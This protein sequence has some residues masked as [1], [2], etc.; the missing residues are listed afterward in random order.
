M[1]ISLIISPLCRMSYLDTKT[2]PPSAEVKSSVP[3][4]H[5]SVM[6]WEEVQKNVRTPGKSDVIRWREALS[7]KYRSQLGEP[8]VWDEDSAINRSE[9]LRSKDLS[10]LTLAAACVDLFG[11]HEAGR[12]LA[13]RT[14]VPLP[15]DID[16]SDKARARGY[17]SKFPQLLLGVECWLPFRRDMIIEEPDVMG[18]KSWFGSLYSLQQQVELLRTFI[19]TA[20]PLAA[21]PGQPASSQ[22]VLRSAWQCSVTMQRLTIQAITHRVPMTLSV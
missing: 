22:T 13:G 15:E 9:D 6:P 14:D 8:L 1:S 4:V 7:R 19:R 18:Y 21:N 3:D 10:M 20:E 17:L 2:I 12:K 5:I 16:L 11:E